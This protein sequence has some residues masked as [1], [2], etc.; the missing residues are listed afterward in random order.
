MSDNNNY[1]FENH[2]K[3]VS[4]KLSYLNVQNKTIRHRIIKA[5]NPN[6]M[7]QGFEINTS[8]NLN[9][10]KSFKIE[11]IIVTFQEPYESYE[12]VNIIERIFRRISF[13]TNGNHII[14]L[15]GWLFNF[16]NKVSC[17]NSIKYIDNKTI[18]IPFPWDDIFLNPLYYQMHVHN[19]LE[20]D[21]NEH[22]EIKLGILEI[23]SET[24]IYHETN[25]IFKDYQYQSFQLDQNDEY[26]NNSITLNLN[27]QFHCSH[28]IIDCGINNVDKIKGIL[29][30]ADA[31]YYNTNA[32]IC[33]METDEI[34]LYTQKIC[35]RFI[36]IPLNGQELIN[37]KDYS[38]QMEGSIN[39]SAFSSIKLILKTYN[40]SINRTIN[41]GFI[42]FNII[43]YLPNMMVKMLSDGIHLLPSLPKIIKSNEINKN[44]I[45]DS[46]ESDY[47]ENTV[48][49][50]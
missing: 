24:T 22:L 32:I 47:D 15:S 2:Y 35:D 10:S 29:L 26:S 33:N 31:E 25:H 4:N 39:F 48:I 44:E 37:N 36:I 19:Y 5:N 13:I 12:L 50:I 42:T 17:K 16:L 38:E 1:I 11:Y 46:Y 9:I 20:I 8:I 28:I 30:K 18:A 23:L 45:F 6:S 34:T 41:I 3:L 14:E 43:K 7:L 40:F 21:N 27:P 49:K